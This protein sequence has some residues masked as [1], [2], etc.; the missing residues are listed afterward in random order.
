[1]TTFELLI[2][3]A[4]VGLIPAV[5]A[6]RKGHSFVT[7]WIFGGLLL[8]V[9]LPL[10]LYQKDKRPRCPE[11]REIVQQEATRCP[12]CNSEIAGRV[13]VYKTPSPT[14]GS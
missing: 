2:L 9:A 3:A 7:W 13:V 14:S 10:A 8:V 5:I 12:H 4:F 6:K 1:M 11:C